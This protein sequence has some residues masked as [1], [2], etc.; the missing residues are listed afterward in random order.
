M[1]DHAAVAGPA[2]GYADSI[3]VTWDD[4]PLGRGATG[5][6]IRTGTT[7]VRGDFTDDPAFAPWRA[8]SPGGRSRSSLCL[9]V[10]VDGEVDGA[11]MVY[12]TEA[13]A[14]DQRAQELFETLASDVGL[15]LDRLRSI[16]ALKE[17]TLE[18]EEQRARIA[19]SEARYRLLAENSSDVV[20]QAYADGTLIWASD[21]VRDVLGWEPADLVG[22]GLD[23]VHTD[24][25]EGF[26]DALRPLE[27]G[28]TAEGEARIAS[29][30][31]SWRWM[32]FNAHRV[33][34]P[35]GPVDVVA[36]RDIDAEVRATRR[37]RPC[38]RPRPADRHGRPTGHGPAHRR[39]AGQPERTST[40]RSPV[41]GR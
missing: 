8:G 36:L 22:R 11:L 28:M 3:T 14:F 31:R 38:H 6:C 15:G 26:P 30:D 2:S 41:R 9:P 5:T 20:W 12:A 23:I 18:I 35:A 13:N 17:K 39:D 16:R 34:G 19:E 37:P 21:S 27:Q 40:R 4:G 29:S 25:L 1:V 10:V 32:A 33:D 7:Q 24:D